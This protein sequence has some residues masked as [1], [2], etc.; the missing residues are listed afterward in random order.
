MIVAEL[1]WHRNCAAGGEVRDNFLLQ[2]LR[3]SSTV[4]CI[5][6]N[7]TELKEG[8][9]ATRTPGRPTLSRPLLISFLIPLIVGFLL[10]S[11]VLLT[12][13][14]ARSIALGAQE[15]NLRAVAGMAANKIERLWIAPRNHSVQ[16][17]S[18]SRTLQRRIR[19]DAEAAELLAEWQQTHAVLDGYFF[20]YYGLNDGTVELYPNLE[21]PEGFDPRV[22]PWYQAG[23][24][25]TGT[26]VWSEP[27]D[28][29][30]TGKRIIS[31]T[32]A[33]S[34][35]AG[36][37]IGVFAVDMTFDQLDKTLAD[38]P[39]PRV[40]TV[41][42]VDA[43]GSPIA[44]SN[45]TYHER[46]VIPEGD[47]DLF[48]HTTRRL[49]NGWRVAVVAPRSGLVHAFDQAAMP[50]LFIA[51]AAFLVL[52]GSVSFALVRLASR[53][54]RLAAYFGEVIDGHESL[55]AVFT[56][57]DEFSELNHRF[58]EVILTARQSEAE[59]LAGERVYRQLIERV[60]IGFFRTTVTGKL[61]YGNSYCASLFEYTPEEL[62]SLPSVLRLYADPKDRQI[63]LQELMRKGEVR[64]RRVQMRKNGGGSIWISVTAVVDRAEAALNDSEIHGFMVDATAQVVEHDKLK[65]YANTDPLTGLVNRRALE[66]AYAERTPKH[67]ACSLIFFDI[68]AFKVLNDS[69]GHDAGDRVLKHIAEVGSSVL[70]ANDIF[71]RYGGDEFAVLLPDAPLDTALSL[72]ERLQE[73]LRSSL[74]PEGVPFVP[75]LSVGVAVR[76]EADCSLDALMVLADSALYRS[77]AA[78]GN[79]VSAARA[80]R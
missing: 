2:E 19:G 11:L 30:I 42:L 43:A 78:G 69:Y 32:A 12:Y 31:T 50:M 77:K 9:S 76:S 62:I 24:S 74:V 20:I 34:D 58:N 68:D 38:I 10:L 45:A 52:F 48:V 55:R 75:A 54:R 44:G 60:S 7:K 6:V 59:R 80:G 70:R 21:L 40:A 17:L 37:R 66:H 22:R 79:T 53:A 25:S 4:V 14:T 63:F 27:Y 15:G 64:D 67:G 36:K 18:S 26:P 16:V 72:A 3:A 13:A 41:Y 49:E 35:D 73:A 33:L 5:T 47:I 39:L 23:M 28:E 51:G 57:A 8:Y 61:T 71:A 56:R 1:S 46:A 65:E 29:I